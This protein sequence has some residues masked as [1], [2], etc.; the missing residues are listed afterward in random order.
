MPEA[1]APLPETMPAGEF[2]AKCLALMDQVKD[3]GGRVIITKYGHPVAML[4]PCPPSQEVPILLG[5][6]RDEIKFYAEAAQPTS[7]EEWER[8]WIDDWKAE[9]HELLP[10]ALR[11]AD[12]PASDNA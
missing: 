12:T 6:C 9:W 1:A 8:E 5:S 11:P 4:A 2:K 3:T 10:E 7:G